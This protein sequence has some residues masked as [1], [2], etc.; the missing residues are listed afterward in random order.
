MKLKTGYLGIIIIV[1]IFGSVALT[2][3]LDLWQ[4]TNSKA[5]AKY[6]QGEFA[7][8]YNPTDIRGSYSLTEISEAFGVPL[9]DL[10]VAFGIKDLSQ[11]ASFQVKNLEAIYA[12]LKTEGKEVGTGSVRL[13]VALYKGLPYTLENGT[14]LPIPA[15]EILKAKAPLTPEQI[16]FIE[17]NSVAVPAATGSS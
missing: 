5:P 3:A 4:T 1:V 7:G 13:F 2:S 11:A 12:A 9:K 10:A 16:Q 8:E 15:V 14:F 6:Q 17:K